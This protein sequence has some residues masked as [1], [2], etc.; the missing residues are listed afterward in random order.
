M[1]RKQ[2]ILEPEYLAIAK[3]RNIIFVGPVPKNVGT[4]TTWRCLAGHEW[5]ASYADVR[6]GANAKCRICAPIGTAQRLTEQNYV[7]RGIELGYEYLGPHPGTAQ[8]KTN[9]RCARGHLR[10]YSINGLKKCAKCRNLQESDYIALADDLGIKWNGPL[11]GTSGEKTYWTCKN[12]HIFYKAYWKL[13][14]TPSCN[15]CRIDSLAKKCTDLAARKRIILIGKSPRTVAEKT[16]WKCQRGHIFISS[17]NILRNGK[18]EYSGCALCRDDNVT[19][20]NNPSWRGGRTSVY[21]N[22]VY[23]SKKMVRRRDRHRCQVCGCRK[24]RNGK[25]LDVHHIIPSRFWSGGRADPRN[26]VTLC[27]KHHRQ[28]EWHLRDSIRLLR[29][30]LTRKYGY[31]YVASDLTYDDLFPNL[32]YLTMR[33]S[34]KPLSWLADYPAFLFAKERSPV[35]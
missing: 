26:L 24:K 14:N 12:G 23:L 32:D 6:N 16:E 18:L 17:Y 8:K 3:L 30:F 25:I 7:D 11:P 5:Q 22:E 28:A 19:G 1:P 4:K 29:E 9:W 35:S 15:Q 13:K 10:S 33:Y 21:E 34:S 31:V 27:A 2:Y 20:E